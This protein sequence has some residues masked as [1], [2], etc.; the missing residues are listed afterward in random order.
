MYYMSTQITY[1]YE[2]QLYVPK[3]E[4]NSLRTVALLYIFA[5]LF[6]GLREHSWVLIDVSAFHLL[7]YVDFLKCVKKFQPHIDK[8]LK[9]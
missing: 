5:G 2:K 7:D 1:F 8:S 6:S 4:S 9:K 3:Q